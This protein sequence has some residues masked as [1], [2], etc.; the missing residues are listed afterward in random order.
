LPGNAPSPAAVPT[1][2]HLPLR[3]ARNKANAPAFGRKPMAPGGKLMRMPII[4][5]FSSTSNRSLTGLAAVS[6]LAMMAACSQSTTPAATAPAT[7]AE[8]PAAALVPTVDPGKATADFA[9]KAANTDMLEIDTSKAALTKTKNA[10][11]KAF[12]QMMITDH[13]KTTAQLKDWAK[14]TSA[15]LPAAADSDTQGK[16]DNI[17]TADAQGFDDKY[18]DTVI[19]AHE[20]GIA[21]FEDYGKNGADQALKKWAADTLPTLQDHFVKAKA[22]RDKVDQKS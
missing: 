17:K 5:L 10:E 22:L 14:T 6:F 8:A 1:G 9:T 19:D 7:E 21:A 13:S 12:A 16:I 20:A 11:V 18:L 2:P 4:S 15:A 3:R